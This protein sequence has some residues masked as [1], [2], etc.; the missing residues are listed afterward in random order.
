MEEWERALV[1]VVTAQT[2]EVAVLDYRSISGLERKVV[3]LL[4]GFDAY[5][6][7]SGRG[8]R[9]SAVRRVVKRVFSLY[10]T[11]CCGGG[12]SLVFWTH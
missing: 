9:S 1:K 10:V 12:A 4:R 3:V 11:A 6:D 8:K 2:D 5:M 7:Y